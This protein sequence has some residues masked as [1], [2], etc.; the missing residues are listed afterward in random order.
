[1]DKGRWTWGIGLWQ[2]DGRRGCNRGFFYHRHF[3]HHIVYDFPFGNIENAPDF[4]EHLLISDFF[5]KQGIP[6]IPG[7]LLESSGIR[8]YCSIQT[9]R[10]N[11]VNAFDLLAG[12]LAIYG[13]SRNIKAYWNGD[14]SIE[15]FIE[16]SK[17]LGIGATELAIAVSTQNPFLLIGAILH[18]AG[19]TKGLL[20]SP[21]KAYFKDTRTIHIGRSTRQTQHQ[22]M[23]G[24]IRNIT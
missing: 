21:S 8:E 5:T 1:M 2:V 6:L 20:I 18:M 10:W 19:T 22:Y 7:E 15:S 9:L 11:F 24:C 3:G 14:N 12:T 16:L 4:I 17:L 23:L 13:G